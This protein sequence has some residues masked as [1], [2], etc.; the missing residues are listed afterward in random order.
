[1]QLIENLSMR[2]IFIGII[3]FSI[4]S[5]ANIAISRE[6]SVADEYMKAY[7]IFDLKKME[8]FYSTNAKFLDPTSEVWGEHAFMKHSKEEIIAGLTS[9]ISN[10]DK[11]SLEYSIRERYES[12]GHNVYSGKTKVTLRKNGVIETSCAPIT[13]II[14]VKDGKVIEHRDYFDY[15]TAEA[16][17]RK[18]DQDC[19]E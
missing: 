1:M 15:K 3:L 18:G 5:Q 6:L 12:A 11:V 14:T 9:F 10:Y 17:N 2:N 4:L 16:T 7:A 13:T 8:K 19:T